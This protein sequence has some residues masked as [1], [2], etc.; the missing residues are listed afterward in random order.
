MR[1][2][3]VPAALLSLAAGVLAPATAA[4]ICTGD[5]PHEACGGRV[6]PEPLLTA[7]FL[8]YGSEV[9]PA[10]AEIEELAP[11]LVEV[12]ML[13]ELTG[14]DDHK[15][16]GG[17]DIPVV[18]VTDE[19]VPSAGKRKVVFS[20]SVH[21]T[22]P[23]GREGGIRYLEDLARWWAADDKDRELFTGDTAFPLGEVMA[24]TE[25]WLGFTNPDGWAGGDLGGDSVVFQRGN[26]NGEDLNREFPTLGWTNVDATPMS[27]PEAQGWVEFVES[28]GPIST[29][30]D[31]H[32]ELTSAN[33]AFSDLM[34]PA[35]QWAP[36]FQARELSIG[37]NV[38]RSIQRKFEEDG[39]VLGDLTGATD[40][41][42]PAAVATGYDVVGYDDGGFMGDWLTQKTGAV[43]IDAEN[44][45]SHLAPGN[46]WFG[47][48]EQAHV[49]AV[50]GIIEGVIVESMITDGI[51]AQLDLGKVAYVLDPR[52]VTSADG[53]GDEP[54]KP[55]DVSRMDY[56]RDLARDAG[57]PVTPVDPAD[58]A[59]GA[60][61]LTAY[62]TLVVAD[63][64]LPPDRLGRTV[65]PST[66][67]RALRAFAD[68]GGQ[69]VLTDGAIEG[70]R[71]FGFSGEDL[72][73][74]DTNAG[75][76]DFGTRDH[77]WE[78]ELEPTASQTYYEVPLG[79][80]PLASAPHHGIT[81]S[82]WEEAGGVTVGT[83]TPGGEGATAFTALGE[84]PS[85]EGKVS[86]FGALLPTPTE[87]WEHAEGLVA[88]GVTIAGGQVFHEMLSYRRPGSTGPGTTPPT[89]GDGTAKPPGGGTPRIP[90]T[91]LADEVPLLALLTA[92][93][94]AGVRRRARR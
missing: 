83:V 29:S 33:D 28:L 22:E 93:A 16:V 82:A 73:S 68:G 46:V 8:Q 25:V 94:A 13:H 11:D 14:N 54:A 61:D 41:M 23:A 52:R 81:S 72:Q 4:P 50:R 60:V 69:L 92:F 70:L 7:T 65:S 77:A 10:L 78:E 71:H 89:G 9:M 17:R 55:Y 76:V 27:E 43:D 12:S 88:Y 42:S 86:I 53:T 74:A 48:L 90:T 64:L 1:R 45:L 51:K 66:Y 36:H 26:D 19:S 44:F 80:P 30:S 5:V 35:G 24:K 37:R 59:S 57:V 15:S 34:W 84:M 79:F 63:V 39:V 58:V 67:G 85:G 62:D 40:T 91:G 56:F 18:R 6:V 32:G 38:V 31:I 47:P 87:G 3:V 21:G 2:I 75:H 49:A 20:L